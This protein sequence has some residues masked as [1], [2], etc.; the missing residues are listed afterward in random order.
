[1]PHLFFYEKYGIITK[2][3]FCIF[4][5]MEK[6]FKLPKRTNAHTLINNK[7]LRDKYKGR[8]YELYLWFRRY[9]IE[10]EGIDC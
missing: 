10:V 5:I 9:G 3:D 8:D 1:M 7:Y 4:V 2:K 6:S